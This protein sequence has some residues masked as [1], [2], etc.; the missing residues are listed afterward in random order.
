LL[1]F[2]H[3]IRLYVYSFFFQNIYNGSDS[4]YILYNPKEIRRIVFHMPGNKKT[5]STQTLSFE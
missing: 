3:I 1:I 5:V 4:F 2:V